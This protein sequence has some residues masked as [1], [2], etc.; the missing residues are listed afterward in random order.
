[1]TE[2]YNK[3]ETLFIIVFFLHLK[4]PMESR[5]IYHVEKYISYLFGGEND[6]DQEQ[7]IYN[8]LLRLEGGL[9]E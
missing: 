2:Y 5:I 8:K 4:E 3:I 9:D 6:Y 1:M 7:R